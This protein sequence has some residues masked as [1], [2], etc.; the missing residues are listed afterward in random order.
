MLSKPKAKGGFTLIETLVSIFLFSL[1]LI[2]IIRGF[3]FAYQL[4]FVRLV[5]DEA[6]KIA[7][8]KMEELRSGDFNAISSSCSPCDPNSTNS[9]CKKTRKVGNK[10]V[11]FGLQ[12]QVTGDTTYKRVT[13]TVCTSYKD[14]SKNDITYTLTSLIANREG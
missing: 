7:Q 3:W 4:N 10:D 1:V 12:I 14:F 11:D 13:V 8:E 2:F 6:V 5:K 9:S